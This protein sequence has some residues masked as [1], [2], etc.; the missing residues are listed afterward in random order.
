[1]KK[2]RII[3][4]NANNDSSHR[5]YEL[6]N[7]LDVIHTIEIKKYK[8]F[9]YNVYNLLQECRSVL[10]TKILHSFIPS[11][12]SVVLDKKQSND[13]PQGAPTK[14]ISHI[15]DEDTVYNLLHGKNEKDLNPEEIIQILDYVISNKCMKGGVLVKRDSANRYFLESIYNIKEVRVNNINL[16]FSAVMDADSNFFRLTQKLSRKYNLKT[17]LKNR[18][19]LYSKSKSTVQ[20]E[21]NSF[22]S[23]K[24]A[25][26]EKYGTS[27]RHEFTMSNDITDIVAKIVSFVS[28]Y[29]VVIVNDD[30]R[31]KNDLINIKSIK[32]FD[33]LLQ[34]KIYV[35]QLMKIDNIRFRDG[36]EKL[37]NC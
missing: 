1:M 15:N 6:N 17:T 34:Q 14:E 31:F 24:K 26:L 5:V 37:M 18:I 16:T 20:F 12:M 36:L 8:A 13:L 27:R 30:E 21:V 2:I 29:R 7:D 10:P 4:F 28:K 35:K 3:K 19:N 9:I 11:M 32:Q 22:F 23:T 25:I 33:K